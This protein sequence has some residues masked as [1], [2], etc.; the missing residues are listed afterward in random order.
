MKKK[1]MFLMI[2]SCTGSFYAD[3][4]LVG[5]KKENV[6]VHKVVAIGDDKINYRTDEYEPNDSCSTE[7]YEQHICD[8]RKPPKVSLMEERVSQVVGYILIKAIIMKQV[9]YQYWVELKQTISNWVGLIVNNKN[10]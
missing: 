1:F 6:H 9:A 2:A 5:I 3:Q 8:Q 4:G 10:S 7:E